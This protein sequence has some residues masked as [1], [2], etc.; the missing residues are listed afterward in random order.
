MGPH[1]SH[2]QLEAEVALVQV[3][4]DNPFVEEEVNQL[5]LVEEAEVV[6]VAEVHQALEA[7]VHQVQEA[8]E[9]PLVQVEEVVVAQGHHSL[10]SL[11]MLHRK[12]LTPRLLL[13]PN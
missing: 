7:G 6:L 12:Q 8:E 3:A 2:K 9:R 11:Q 10:R 1:P 13:R 4:G 5:A